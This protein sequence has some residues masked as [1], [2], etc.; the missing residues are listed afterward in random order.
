M[1]RDEVEDVLSSC[2]AWYGT[3]HEFDGT[4]K[5][6]YRFIKLDVSRIG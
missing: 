6:C 5:L 1:L 3:Q 2:L 4:S